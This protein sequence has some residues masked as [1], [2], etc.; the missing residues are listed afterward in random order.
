MLT[1]A[2]VETVVLRDRTAKNDPVRIDDMSD[3]RDAG[4]PSDAGPGR[5]EGNDQKELVDLVARCLRHENDALTEFVCR[6]ERAVIGLCLRMLRDRQE[7]E[8]AAQETFLRAIRNLHKW[9]H[10]RPILPWL[11]TIAANRCRTMLGKRTRRP[12]VVS[13]VVDPGATERRMNDMVEE[14]DRALATLP[15][16]WRDV[17]VMHYRGGLGVREIADVVGC[18]S[19]TVKTWLFRARRQMAEELKGRGFESGVETD[20]HQPGERS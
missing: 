17:V 1:Y 16:R 14:V 7:A 4:P 6:F 18:A 19:G 11:Q 5:S 9:D 3:V 20:V 8:D 15:S 10:E 13:E 12:I 2:P